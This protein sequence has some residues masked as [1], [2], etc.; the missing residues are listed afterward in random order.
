MLK[1]GTRAPISAHG[2]GRSWRIALFALCL[3][4]AALAAILPAQA[5]P[6]VTW[7]DG[8]PASDKA[9]HL[10]G[11]AALGCVFGLLFRQVL[12]G[13]I[14]LLAFGL[15][16]EGA[17]AMSGLGREGDPR[18]AAANGLGLAAAF[19]VIVAWRAFWS[20]LA[21]RPRAAQP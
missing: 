8:A 14:G 13:V 10:L 19:I 16:L 6:R 20:R 4:L 21:N 1:A 3:A 12:W 15:A 7:P 5:L 2:I 9:L 18:D 17:Q 11:F